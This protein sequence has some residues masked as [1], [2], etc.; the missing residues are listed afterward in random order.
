MLQLTGELD[1]EH[2]SVKDLEQKV[3]LLERSS[4]ANTDTLLRGM[5]ERHEKEILTFRNQIESITAKLNAKVCAKATASYKF[6]SLY[7]NTSRNYLLYLCMYKLHFF[8]FCMNLSSKIGMRLMHSFFFLNRKTRSLGEKAVI[9]LT[10]EPLT[11][12]L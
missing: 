11:L 7:R 1:A 6:L 10:T 4:V 3:S 5:Q 8:S 2:M 12:V 9:L